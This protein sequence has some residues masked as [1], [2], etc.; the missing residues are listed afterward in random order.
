MGFYTELK[1]EYEHDLKPG[2]KIKWKNYLNNNKVEILTVGDDWQ[3][4]KRWGNCKDYI[5]TTNGRVLLRKSVIK[6]LI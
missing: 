5:V 4:L 6:I 1:G 3:E 2:D